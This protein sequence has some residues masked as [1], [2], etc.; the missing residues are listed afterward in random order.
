MY[1]LLV[2][3]LIK[4]RSDPL[5]KVPKLCTLGKGVWALWAKCP[6]FVSKVSKSAQ[7]VQRTQTWTHRSQRFTSILF[8]LLLKS[9]SSSGGVPAAVKVLANFKAVK[10]KF[11]LCFNYFSCYQT[12]ASLLRSISAVL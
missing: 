6:N 5:P 7:S 11:C 3:D 4:R 10:N 2:I 8:T 1:F 9:Q 12:E